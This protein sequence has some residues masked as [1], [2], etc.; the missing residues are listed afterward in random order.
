MGLFNKLFGGASPTKKYDAKVAAI[1]ALE[2]QMAALT[3]AQLRAKTGEFRA[4]LKEGESL[5]D[6]LVEAFA[7]VR[8]AGKRVL[9]M[10]HFDVQLIGG[11]VLNDGNIAEMKTGEGKTLVATLPSYLNALAGE[12]VHVVTVNDYLAKR[13]AEWMGKLH[14]FLGLSVGVILSQ[15]PAADRR[16]AYACDIT[17]GTNSEFGFDYLRDN[18]CV[19]KKDMV[20]RELPF[21]IVD[22][23]DSILIDEARTPLIISGSSSDSSEMYERADK[24]VKTLKRGEDQKEMSKYEMLSGEDVFANSGDYSVDPKRRTV[25]LTASGVEKAERYFNVERLT[26]I[27]NTELNHYIQQALR[28]NAVFKKDVDYVVTDG[29]VMIVDEFTGRI[30]YGRRYSEGLHQAIEAKEGVAIKNE[31]KTLATITYQNYFRMYKKL[32]GMTGTAKTEEA[33]FMGI[34]G[35]EVVE[36]PTNRP[37]I[38]KDYDDQIYLKQEYKFDAIVDEIC[39]VHAT[40][41]PVLVGTV[42]VERSE[43]VSELLRRRG[44]KHEVLNAKNHRKEAEIIAQAG[45][46]NAVTIATNMAGRGTDILLGG[47]PDYLA[48]R[49]MRRREYDEEMIEEATGHAETDNE[50]I[51]A[52]REVYRQLHEEYKKET[53]REHDEVVRLGG[54]HIIGTERHDSRRIDNQLRGRAARQGDPGS[55]RFYLSFDDDLLRFFGGEGLKSM[56]TKLSTAAGSERDGMQL[57]MLTKQI[58]N[59]QKRVEQMHFNARKNVLQYDDVMNKQRE[60]IY[61]QRRR[62]LLGEDV[63][64]TVQQQIESL[65][66]DSVNSY[67]AEGATPDQWDLSALATYLSRFFFAPGE[68]PWANLSDEERKGLKREELKEELLR[69]AK[70]AYAA[71]EEEI[72]AA[73]ISMRDV[74]REVLLRVVDS[75]WVEHI[76]AMD[77]LRDSVS[78]QAYGNRDPAKEYAIAGYD[79][80]EEMIASINETMLSALYHVSVK[81]VPAARKGVTG[82]ASQKSMPTGAVAAPGAGQENPQQTQTNR[83]ATEAPK[84]FV[85]QKRVGR[86]DPCPCG[87]GKKYKNCCG[88]NE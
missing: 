47:N 7:V 32:S 5:D 87:S 56:M 3:D 72:A 6:L 86:N 29:K 66:N 40:G 11:M 23:V 35:L 41:R 85:A 19:Y 44:V 52:A 57:G 75:H 45:K 51:L 80:F 78:L 15:M 55:T 18:M 17:Y 21:A 39:E 79:M 27:D 36:I 16:A 65:V 74:E 83:P 24:F 58:E 20:Q 9:G 1:N 13:D 10:R 43:H 63:S 84:P 30:M 12:G 50:E 64:E 76:D 59:A 71:R 42:S 62:V 14:R 88:K 37:N 49:E 77:R 31:S 8:E 73:K 26:D 67:C 54:L 60:I 81:S 25:T 4:R 82:S 28:A 33:E 61:A 48:R 69:R 53:D 2:P 34:Y 70:E 22:E 46:V 68:D 38:R